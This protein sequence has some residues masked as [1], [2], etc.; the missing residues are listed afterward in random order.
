MIS[1]KHRLTYQFLSLKLQLGF[2]IIGVSWVLPF[3]SLSKLSLIRK[4]NLSLYSLPP[5]LLLF[6]GLWYFI[7]LYVNVFLYEINVIRFTDVDII[8]TLFNILIVSCMAI[9]ITI[10]LYN[11]Y[12]YVTLLIDKKF[13]FIVFLALLLTYFF[14]IFNG[15]PYDLTFS[16]VIGLFI[17]IESGNILGSIDTTDF[18]RHDWLNVA[19][20]R[21]TILERYPAATSLIMVAYASAILAQSKKLSEKII[22]EIILICFVISSITRS[23]W[24]GYILA[25]IICSML[26]QI[27]KTKVV[28]LCMIS[29][30]IILALEFS[31]YDVIRSS[32]SFR[33][34]STES[35]IELYRRALIVDNISEFVF[36]HGGKILGYKMSGLKIG[37]HSTIIGSFFKGGIPLVSIYLFFICV[38]SIQILKLL[39]SEEPTFR[40]FIICRFILIFIIWSFFEDFDASPLVSGLVGVFIGSLCLRLKKTSSQKIHYESQN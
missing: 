26:S 35:R 29:L 31:P 11:D 9:Y 13:F 21:L 39:L 23:I 2:Y 16:S 18:F 27:Q 22:F 6:Y 25:T 7:C 40:D 33:T 28:L 32:G 4:L 19:L 1:F 30:M 17:N 5:V 8:P 37:S 20:P 12:N 14:V 34:G 15:P 38:L 24:L 10:C 3:L 36:G